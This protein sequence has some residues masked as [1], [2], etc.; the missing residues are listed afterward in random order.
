M[1]VL[2]GVECGQALGRAHVGPFARV[3]LA[4]DLTGGD[5]AAQ[6]GR[7]RGGLAL[8][9]AG[10]DA[11]PGR[12]EEGAAVEGDGAEGVARA[13][14]LQQAAGGEGEVA[15]R[16]VGRVGHEPEVGEQ[17]AGGKAG[18]VLRGKGKLRGVDVA[19]HGPEN[20]WAAGGQPGQGAGDAASGFK[21]VAE[22]ALFFGE[23]EFG[24]GRQAGRPLDA[25]RAAWRLRPFPCPLAY[26]PAQPAGVD[27]DA[28]HARS[29]QGARV[30]LHEG[31]AAH[32]Q[33]G[34]GAGVGQGPHALAPACGQDD[35]GGRWQAVHAWA[36]RRVS[37]PPALRA[38][39]LFPLW[40]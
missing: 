31:L 19:R 29:G 10:R 34:F 26:L 25:A 3:E 32:G 33:Q 6:Q 8:R 24:P 15:C 37:P 9:V 38:L 35:G 23:D 13:F 11:A 5:G 21:G 22:V 4:A 28:A 36:V 17:A 7:E 18:G 14:G 16:V 40:I 1:G 20:V 2:R 30:P 27:D 12:L 39:A